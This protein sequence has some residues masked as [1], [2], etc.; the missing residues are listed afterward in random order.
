LGTQPPSPPCAAEGNENVNGA[1]GGA[2]WLICPTILD[3][4]NGA[5]AVDAF[6]DQVLKPNGAPLD[7]AF[8][9]NFNCL[10]TTGDFKGSTACP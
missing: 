1:D 8:T 3:P 10:Q 9:N 7:P 5:I 6:I 2:V 4:R